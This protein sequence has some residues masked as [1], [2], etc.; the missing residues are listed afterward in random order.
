M[1]TDRREDNRRLFFALWPDVHTAKQLANLQRELQMVGRPVS[2]NNLHMT[3]AFIGGVDSRCARCLRSVAGAVNFPPFSLS[4][5]R[6]GY[7]DR[8]KVCWIGPRR[9]P[10]ALNSLRR[11]LL[12]QLQTCG[13]TP[14]DIHFSPHASLARKSARLEAKPF[15][16]ILWPVMDFVLVESRSAGAGAEYHV[17]E[18]YPAL[19]APA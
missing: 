16:P 7:F 12:R 4:L 17:L 3:L 11:D 5:D 14:D 2:R 15:V 8:P 6:L 13:Y 10:P 9:T 18:R 1:I 19:K